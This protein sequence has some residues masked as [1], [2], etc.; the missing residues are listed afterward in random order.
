MVVSKEH[1]DTIA[2]YLS[3]SVVFLSVVGAVIKALVGHETFKQGA[4]RVAAGS[5]V[6][7][8]SNKLVLEYVDSTLYPIVI[9]LIGYGGAELCEVVQNCFHTFIKEKIDR[10]LAI[11][12]G[13]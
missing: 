3:T 12:K 10:F 5:A 4:V 6:A 9:F 1:F 8:V 2:D 13:E 11:R 7:F